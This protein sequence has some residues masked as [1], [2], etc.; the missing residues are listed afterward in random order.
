M[1]HSGL[2]KR[3]GRM[4]TED[5]DVLEDDRVDRECSEPGAQRA[6]D[7]CRGDEA[8]MVGELRS[9]QTCSR[10]AKT[11]V[12]A[13]FFD[14]SDTV[15]LKWLGRSRIPGIEPGRRLTVRGRVAVADGV[16]TIYNPYYEL[17]SIND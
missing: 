15:R 1:S 6:K 17:H 14:G 4:L 3:L 16:K 10:N 12:I 13:E 11:G 9:V 8:T 5:L 2:L 7:C